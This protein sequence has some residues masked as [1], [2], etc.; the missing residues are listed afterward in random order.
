MDWARPN[1]GQ[2]V[3]AI[4]IKKLVIEGAAG[5]RAAVQMQCRGEIWRGEILSLHG[6]TTLCI[7]RGSP[8]S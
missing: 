8:F 5:V 3:E 2:E 6:K 7:P 4:T 1:G